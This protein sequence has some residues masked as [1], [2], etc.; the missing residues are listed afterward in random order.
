MT[1]VKP[2]LF[3]DSHSGV[4]EVSMALLDEMR[5]EW[6]VEMKSRRRWMDETRTRTTSSPRR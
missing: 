1:W 3:L 6:I 2:T 5:M 4:D